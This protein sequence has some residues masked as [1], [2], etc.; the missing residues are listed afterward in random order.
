[1]TR[2]CRG[3]A[4]NIFFHLFTDDVTYQHVRLLDAGRVAGRYVDQVV[5]LTFHAAPALAGKAGDDHASAL[6]GCYSL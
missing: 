3:L 2:G 6:C 1:M 4:K 5:S